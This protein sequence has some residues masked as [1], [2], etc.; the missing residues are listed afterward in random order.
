MKKNIIYI[1]SFL[2]VSFLA[3]CFFPLLTY[4]SSKE[5]ARIYIKDRN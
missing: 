3:Y 2:A 1:T 4:D 5:P